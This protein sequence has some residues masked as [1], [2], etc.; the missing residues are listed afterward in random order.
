VLG[1]GELVPEGEPGSLRS[2]MG[3]KVRGEICCGQGARF[4]G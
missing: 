1:G 3:T 4:A 2:G